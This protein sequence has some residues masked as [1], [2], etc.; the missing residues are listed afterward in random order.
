MR[1]QI[2]GLLLLLGVS[3]ALAAMPNDRHAHRLHLE[4][5][6]AD[7]KSVF[8]SWVDDFKRAYREN[9]EEY[10]RRF[11]IWC[12]NLMFVDSYNSEDKT[13]WLGLN[14]FA[15]YTRD[16]YRQ[17]LGYRADLAPERQLQSTAFRYANTKPPPSVDWR[18]KGAVTDVKNQEQCGSCWAFSTVGAV[19][20]INAIVTDKLV[21]LS[22]QELVDCDTLQDH[23]C[24]GGL[25]DFAFDFIKKNGGLDTEK[26]YKYQ[27]EEEKCNVA[28]EHRHVV[29]IDGHEDVPGNDE[30]SLL[31]AVANQPVSVAIEAD[32]REFQLYAG[33]VFE[34][35]CGTA[36]D[37]GVLV[38]GYGSDDSFPVVGHKNESVDYWIVKNSWSAGW[39]DKGYIR[40]ARSNS[41]NSP[42]QCGVAMQASY[43]IKTGPNPP[44]TPPTPS[45]TPGPPPGPSPPPTPQPEVCDTSTQCPTGSTCCCMREYFGY[46]FTWACCPLPEAVCCDDHVHCCP[47]NLPVCDVTAG[48]CLN[49]AGAGFDDSA[50]WFTKTP[51]E[52][53]GRGSQWIPNLP[54]GIKNAA[55]QVAMA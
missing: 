16:E 10:E 5:A 49:K 12:D 31:K 39:G 23:G 8:S 38:V 47:S 35:P 15:D 29:S 27:A 26:D 11:A 40:L 30:Q 20:G 50:E 55:Q 19:E 33:G 45:P 6:K 13:H 36:L 46:C 44:P 9:V 24:H 18:E 51:A 52:K 21:A 28:K 1:C 54:H 3:C 7:P 34:A 41:K 2:A 25:M 22:E 43:P 53:T 42:G 48:R 17:M 4:Q 14:H 37:H 32:Q